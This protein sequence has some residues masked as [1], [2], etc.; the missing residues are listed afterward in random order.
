MEVSLQASWAGCLG[1]AVAEKHYFETVAQV[2][3]EDIAVV[4]EHLFS[5]G[6]L[7]EMACCPGTEF[8]PKPPEAELAAAQAR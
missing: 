6:E 5:P 1:G 8:T 3:F 2:G 4:S 7:A